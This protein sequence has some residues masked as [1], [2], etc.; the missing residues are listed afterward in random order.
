MFQKPAFLDWNEETNDRYLT[1]GGFPVYTYEEPSFLARAFRRARDFINL[2]EVKLPLLFGIAAGAADY[3]LGVNKSFEVMTVAGLTGSIYYKTAISL[4]EWQ[5][6]MG[7]VR[8][9]NG[10]FGIHR[11]YYFDTKPEGFRNIDKPSHP[12]DTPLRSKVALHCGFNAAAGMFFSGL[13]LYTLYEEPSL[14]AIGISAIIATPAFCN[15][16]RYYK[17]IKGDCDA[18]DIT[19]Q[20]PPRQK[21]PEKV[22]SSVK[23]SEVLACVPA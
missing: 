4:L 15:A 6:Q 19:D 12:F 9:Q 21:K 13:P 2:P 20:L 11:P 3:L 7:P 1:L 22:P 18:W 17:V 8:S 5:T 23:I 10:I 14:S 16:W